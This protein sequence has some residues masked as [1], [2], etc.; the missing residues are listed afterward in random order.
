MSF[1]LNREYN[2]LLDEYENTPDLS[3]SDAYDIE[4]ELEAL[5]HLIADVEL[6]NLD[7]EWECRMDDLYYDDYWRSI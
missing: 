3:D 2:E 6:S 4:L 1:Y 5:Q 7:D